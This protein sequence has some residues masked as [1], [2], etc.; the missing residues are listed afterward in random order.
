MITEFENYKIIMESH[1]YP[2]TCLE[3]LK[4]GKIK[5]L[6]LSWKQPFLSLM[7]H[8][9]IETRTWK[10]NYR[11]WVLMCASLV[12]YNKEKL[13]EISGQVQ[14]NRICQTINLDEVTKFNGHAM[15]IGYLS[16]CRPMYREDKDL[17]FTKYHP[18][19][20]CH[21]YENVFPI[22]PIPWKGTQGWKKVDN[23]FIN[24]IELPK[25]II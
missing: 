4:E 24:K 11:G 15:A 1:I 10:T 23:D 19:L 2:E 13:Y 5:L 8:G 22:V 9:K 12:G 21:I 16:D 7:L 17:T 20:F 25:I 3:N 14:F 18:S 6:A